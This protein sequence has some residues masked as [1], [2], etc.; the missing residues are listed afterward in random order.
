M[1]YP[2]FQDMEDEDLFKEQGSEPREVRCKYC[3]ERD[4]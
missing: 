3:N 2:D 4:L 1:R